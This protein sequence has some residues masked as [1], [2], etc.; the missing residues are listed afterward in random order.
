[1][2]KEKSLR[3]IVR[4]LGKVIIGYSGGIDST[5]V[6]KIATEELKGDALVVISDSPSLPRSELKEAL[7]VANTHRFFT[8][9]IHTQE[10]EKEEY[11]SNPTN[12]CFY[13]KTELY[14]DLEKMRIAENYNFIL[15]GAN[16]D[17]LGDFR[18]GRKAASQ[19]GVRSVLIEAQ[20]N[21]N[22]VRELAKK[23]G[24]PN[25]D[26]PAAACLSSR[27]PYGTSI[28]KEKLT[29]VELAEEF[30]KNLG[31]RNVRVRYHLEVARIE[32]DKNNFDVVL[33][34]A[35]K[36][37]TYFNSIGFKYTALDLIGFRSGSMNENSVA[38]G[39]LPVA[40]EQ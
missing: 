28:T 15:D 8:R 22:E 11:L 4:S 5:L 19:K 40:S 24:L 1:M 6:A 35:S 36:I 13:C 29:Q 33:E 3:Q 20:L 9:I 25:F 32:V 27:F 31:L 12:R 21:K 23:L 17:D 16:L 10:A 26:K 2:S 18:P 14:G 34:N 39:Q 7:E 37:Y 38:S 30:I